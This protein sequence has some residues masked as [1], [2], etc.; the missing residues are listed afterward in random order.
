MSKTVFPERVL[1]HYLEKYDIS[2]HCE[3][4]GRLS[5]E[6]AGDKRPILIQDLPKYILSLAM[7]TKVRLFFAQYPVTVANYSL[8]VQL[9]PYLALRGGMNRIE[10]EEDLKGLPVLDLESEIE[11]LKR[12]DISGERID[13]VSEMTSGGTLGLIS[14][15]FRESSLARSR[16]LE[17]IDE[18]LCC[19]FAYCAKSNKPAVQYG[20]LKYLSDLLE[21]HLVRP[22]SKQVHYLLR[23]E[24]L[25][26]AWITS[27]DYIAKLDPIT[28]LMS[29]K[30]YLLCLEAIAF[31]Q[32]TKI[33]SAL[34]GKINDA[35][36]VFAPKTQTP[37]QV[38]YNHYVWGIMT[39]HTR[40]IARVDQSN[41]RVAYNQ[42]LRLARPGAE[43]VDRVGA[44]APDK[45]EA[46]GEILGYISSG[47][48]STATCLM[49]GI[50][51]LLGSALNPPAPPVATTATPKGANEDK[52]G[53]KKDGKDKGL[54]ANIKVLFRGVS[55]THLLDALEDAPDW[56]SRGYQAVYDAYERYKR[57]ISKET[58][59]QAL[60]KQI[61]YLKRRCASK[62]ISSVDLAIIHDIMLSTALKT[63]EQDN[64]WHVTFSVLEFVEENL[65]SSVISLSIRRKIV[66]IIRDIKAYTNIPGL[67]FKAFQI[68]SK[69]RNDYHL[70][71][72]V[73]P[74]LVELLDKQ[75]ASLTDMLDR[76]EQIVREIRD[77]EIFLS[78][79]NQGYTRR[80]SLAA[81]CPNALPLPRLDIDSCI[82][83][84]A[85]CGLLSK[86]FNK[87]RPVAMCG[88]KHV[89]KTFLARQ[90]IELYHHQYSKIYFLQSWS[91]VEDLKT[92]L[93]LEG[94]SH[95]E[96][97]DKLENANQR[98]LLILDFGDETLPPGEERAW[99]PNGKEGGDL[100]I[101]ANN[102]AY[103]FELGCEEENTI[104]LTPAFPSDARDYLL[105]GFK[106]KHSIDAKL[107][108]DTLQICERLLHW[109]PSIAQLRREIVR[110]GNSPAE[111]LGGLSHSTEGSTYY[112]V[113]Q[114]RRDINTLI[115][116]LDATPF[117]GLTS[118]DVLVLVAFCDTILPEDV[119]NDFI[120][121]C[122]DIL[123]ARNSLLDPL[124]N[125]CFV[126]RQNCSVRMNMSVRRLLREI[127]TVDQRISILSTLS[128]VETMRDRFG[129]IDSKSLLCKIFFLCGFCSYSRTIPLVSR[130]SHSTI[131]I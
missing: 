21:K 8:Y 16:G 41:A 65:C 88:I 31:S 7:L 50:S 43:L 74:I 61:F 123:T 57:E 94:P 127:T 53:K 124:T 40:I 64:S 59:E 81:K 39:V 38:A 131:S 110:N 29:I 103:A 77:H 114:G 104:I 107:Q 37:S 4:N 55:A 47:V 56:P 84:Q 12:M 51:S 49:G 119:I 18:D 99:I 125:H 87:R 45:L 86:L 58:S 30:A 63:N 105:S 1:V 35:I 95:A 72:D 17:P 116:L 126:E 67:I 60:Y 80:V 70:R 11:K 78:L 83:R 115:E 82:K 118:R 90:Y 113:D 10:A 28:R 44:A 128:H 96:L 68:L 24:C 27:D 97:R 36:Q 9:S 66:S 120:G 98:W 13:V 23:I 46:I 92:E 129:R 76:E 108:N 25:L 52:E 6:R 5:A 20:S 62:G 75:T 34:Y 3:I 19:C 2:V 14:K 100:L 109:P 91:Q 73:E 32:L 101:L 42:V 122:D 106:Q 117:N 79:L 48:I 15:L 102:R 22:K 111:V 121:P 85:E 26:R 93:E 130:S 69:I 54:A 71:Q 89:G 112:S 33:S